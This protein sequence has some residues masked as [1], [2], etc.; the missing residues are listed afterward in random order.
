MAALLA[1]SKNKGKIGL[2]IVLPVMYFLSIKTSGFTHGPVLCIFRSLT[3]HPCP[4]CGS[5]RSI[6]A[7]AQGDLISAWQFNQLTLLGVITYASYVFFPKNIIIFAKKI[8]QAFQ[9]R[10]RYELNPI[11]VLSLG[12]VFLWILNLQ[13]WS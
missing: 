2:L 10:R 6:G 3:G 11:L 7:L 5:I 8:D 1:L 12:F 9:L 13:R 4:A